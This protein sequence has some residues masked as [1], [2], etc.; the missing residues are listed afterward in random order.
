MNTRESEAYIMITQN[1]CF[2]KP[3]DIEKSRWIL[4]SEFLICYRKTIYEKT[5]KQ[6]NKQTN[7]LA[8]FIQ[9]NRAFFEIRAARRDI[10]QY[11]KSMESVIVSQAIM[12]RLTSHHIQAYKVTSDKI[13]FPSVLAQPNVVFLIMQVQS[14]GAIG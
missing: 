1:H 7:N 2:Q 12:P 11:R 9:G 5:N 13:G 14:A 8:K 3:V 10:D 4:V 6:T